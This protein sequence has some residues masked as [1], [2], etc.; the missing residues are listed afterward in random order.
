MFLDSIFYMFC[1]CYI[2][3]LHQSNWQE[4]LQNMFQFH[5]AKIFGQFWRP[6]FY[7]LHFYHY[8]WNDGDTWREV[9]SLVGLSKNKFFVFFK[10]IAK[11]WWFLCKFSFFQKMMV[12]IGGG[13][14]SVETETSARWPTKIIFFSIFLSY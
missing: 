13:R 1:V 3:N 8:L 14:E 6:I 10:P 9:S 11:M 12:K 2:W 7:P 5:T 4:V